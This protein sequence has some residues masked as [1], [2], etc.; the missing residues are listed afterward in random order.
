MCVSVGSGVSEHQSVH[1]RLTLHTATT[2]C[3]TKDDDADSSNIE[4]EV[5]PI[6]SHPSA[7]EKL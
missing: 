7:D 3:I 2:H 6:N 4:Q 5:I 1:P